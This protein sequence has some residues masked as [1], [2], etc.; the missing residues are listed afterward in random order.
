MQFSQ[1]YR[2]SITKHQKMLKYKNLKVS[3]WLQEDNFYT[4]RTSKC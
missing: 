2:P 4:E 3:S 1:T